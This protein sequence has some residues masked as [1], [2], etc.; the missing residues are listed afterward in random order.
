MS[1]YKEE[2]QECLS[3]LDDNAGLSNEERETALKTLYDIQKDLDREIYSAFKKFT[4]YQHVSS[5]IFI[6]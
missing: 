2:Y 4:A 3:L 6:G 5:V 1:Y